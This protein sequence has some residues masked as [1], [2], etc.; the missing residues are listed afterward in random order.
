[1]AIEPLEQ[2]DFIAQASRQLELQ[3]LRRVLHFAFQLGQ[4]A[5]LA[6]LQKTNQ[7]VDVLA[8][9]VFADSQVAR[10]GAL[11]DASQKARPEPA[12]A[13]V[14]V[15]DVQ[16]AGAKLEYPLQHLNGAAQ[17]S[18]VGE[19]SEQPCAFVA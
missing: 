15:I 3:L 16:G 1:A 5:D 12:P 11:L 2:A 19:R 13:I 17:R 9:L 4:Q 18:G 14:P 6:A 10:R 8:I 7:A